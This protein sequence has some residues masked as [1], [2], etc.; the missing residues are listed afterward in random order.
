MKILAF[1][2][3]SSGTSLNRAL[4]SHAGD[5]L[6]AA[7]PS[8]EIELLDLRDYDMPVFSVDRENADGI[9]EPAKRFFA[10]IGDADALLISYAE[11][12]GS[13]TAAFKNVFDWASRIQA[14]VFQ[15]KPMTVLSTSPGPGGGRN[16]LA[17][18]VASAPHF[19]GEVVS[20]LSVPRFHT[21]FDA[22]AGGL[23][24]PELRDA[25]EVAVA[26]LAAHLA[27]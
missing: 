12:N 1:A 4:V 14:K 23:K 22:D 5:R 16:V 26:A 25:L 19:N 27:P 15:D 18:A 2:A 6:R 9:L 10:K 7:L 20:S 24:D 13:Y 17:A 8:A 3:S 11:H 21:A